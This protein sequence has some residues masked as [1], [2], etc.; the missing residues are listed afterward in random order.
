[1]QNPCVVVSGG[2]GAHT[3]AAECRSRGLGTHPR[4]LSRRRGNGSDPSRRRSCRLRDAC[5]PGQGHTLLMWLGDCPCPQWSA[6]RPAGFLPA[7]VFSSGP[8][9]PAQ[10]THPQSNTRAGLRGGAERPA[11]TLSCPCRRSGAVFFQKCSPGP[12]WAGTREEVSC[13]RS[14]VTSQGSSLKMSRGQPLGVEASALAASLGKSPAPGTSPCSVVTRCHFR[15]YQPRARA[16]A[17]P[18]GCTA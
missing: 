17:P 15:S 7:S 12:L 6:P 2:R 9:S 5:T 4:R 1:M 3:W 11:A 16:H 10:S 18:T 14:R 13:A 8:S